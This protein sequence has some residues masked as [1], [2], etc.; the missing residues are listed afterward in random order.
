MPLEYITERNGINNDKLRDHGIIELNGCY[1]FAQIY[2]DEQELAA[3]FVNRSNVRNSDTWVPK[4]N[5]LSKEQRN[6]IEGALSN[7]CSII[8]GGAGTGKTMLIGE[9]A[10]ILESDEKRYVCGTF[11]GKAA[12]R[13]RESLRASI[14]DWNNPPVFTFHS[15]IY[16]KRLL[17]KQNIKNLYESDDDNDY[18]NDKI[19]T[20]PAIS[21]DVMDP[22]YLII[23]EGSM[24][25][26]NLLLRFIRTFPSISNIIFV[27][28]SC[29][30]EAFG[31]WGLP[32]NHLINAQAISIY[33]LN[34]NFRTNDNGI[35]INAN[36]IRNHSL[37]HPV[38]LSVTDNFHYNYGN[39][40]T[41]IGVFH[42]LL[43]QGNRIKSI[44]IL[45]ATRELVHDINLRCQE[46]YS[47]GQPYIETGRNKF[48][49]G[50]PVIM[51]KNNYDIGI[52]NGEEGL[53]TDID[54]KNGMISVTFDNKT[55]KFKV[56]DDHKDKLE[57]SKEPED[58][59]NLL[60]LSYAQTVH[61]SQ[62]S[63]Y[64]YVILYM[65]YQCRLINRNLIYTAIT[66]AQREIYCID[67]SYEIQNGTGKL[68]DL[69]YEVL[70]QL[71]I[72]ENSIQQLN[73]SHSQTNITSS[74][75][76]LTMHINKLITTQK[77]NSTQNNESNQN[78]LGYF[79][80]PINNSIQ[81][82]E[83][84]QSSENLLMKYNRD[85]L[86]TL[87]RKIIRATLSNHQMTAVN[88]RVDSQKKDPEPKYNETQNVESTQLLNTT[89]IRYNQT[90]YKP[91]IVK[92]KIHSG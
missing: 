74:T 18:V 44:K 1:L 13:L 56:T 82:I 41:V 36:Q 27:G 22:E 73:E 80:E 92:L 55:C 47:S 12:A 48:C 67:S 39:I 16:K 17:Y 70:P 54:N 88:N 78:Q 86:Q 26:G 6:A 69:R 53:V 52:M 42:S 30:L 83:V 71:L 9:I 15:M 72:V 19:S 5:R 91:K 89:P 59:I 29:Q 50:D 24:V 32:F 65:P 81:N 57:K 25:T 23:D 20:I 34:T 28:D 84:N 77:K 60:N 68:P 11:T 2:E 10:R 31:N 38:E 58:N 8:T 4:H 63:E 37:N 79:P 64:S 45:C 85:T 46:I 35:L 75:S 66:R 49:R 14:K 21:D 43:D 87:T 3:W 40:D 7:Q 76:D 61:K 51:T 62:G 90:T 33:H